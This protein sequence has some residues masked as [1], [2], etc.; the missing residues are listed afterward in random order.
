MMQTQQQQQQQ[1]LM[2]SG[3]ISG[4][5]SFN[6]SLTKEDE[7]MSKS[8]LSTFRAKEE[9]IEK[10]KLEV[11]E[12]VQAQ[13][14]RIEEE[15]KRLAT[16]RE[17]LEGLADPMRKE[18]ALVRK[19]IDSVNKELKPLGQSCQK[20]EREYKEALEAFNE[21]NKEKVQLITRLMELVSESERLRLKKLEEL[22]KSIETIH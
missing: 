20:K 4:S 14:G 9:E 17:E 21:K 1:A 3:Q 12:K 13:L 10:K 8:A 19:K 11:K 16:I 22:S 15:T 18:V 5:L 7:E 2:Q 6:G